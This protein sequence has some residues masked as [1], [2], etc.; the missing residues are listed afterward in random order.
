MHIL[1]S[2]LKLT[3]LPDTSCIS[4][5]C[6]N[7]GQ[8]RKCLKDLK[9]SETVE[10]LE[11]PLLPNIPHFAQEAGLQEGQGFSLPLIACFPPVLVPSHYSWFLKMVSSVSS[12]ESSIVCIV[13]SVLASRHGNKPRCL[14]KLLFYWG[15]GIYART[16]VK[17]S[18]IKAATTQFKSQIK[19]QIFFYRC[20]WISVLPSVIVV[21]HSHIYTSFPYIFQS[22]PFCERLLSFLKNFLLFAFAVLLYKK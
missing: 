22:L 8:K 5:L 9:F 7:N 10:R 21:F 18:K 4:I 6:T 11:R 12:K 3:L 20:M 17:P 19:E 2:I 15:G 1:S 14:N 16:K 13:L